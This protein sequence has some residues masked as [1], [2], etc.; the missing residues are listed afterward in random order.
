MLYIDKR[1]DMARRCNNYNKHTPVDR[2]SKIYEAKTDKTEERNRHFYNNIW[3]L[4][5]PTHNNRW[6]NQIEVNRR[7]NTINP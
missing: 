4:H 5:Y 6:N 3:R 7:F 1:F 2:P